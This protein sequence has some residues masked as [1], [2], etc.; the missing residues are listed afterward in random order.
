M[1]LAFANPRYW[2]LAL[3]SH[4]VYAIETRNQSILINVYIHGIH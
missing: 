4:Y 1:A 2:R 3:G